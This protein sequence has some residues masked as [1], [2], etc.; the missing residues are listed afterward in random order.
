MI[1]TLD[2]K[3][4]SDAFEPG[5]TLQTL[6]SDVRGA[7]LGSR[8]VVSIMI[9]GRELA[10]DEL[11]ARLDQPVEGVAQIELISAEPHEL[12]ASAFREVSLLLAQIG[13]DHEAL[14]DQM[15]SGETSNAVAKFGELL[16][17]WQ[18]CQQAVAEGS[19]M[20][21]RDMTS[22]T[23]SDRTVREHLDALA[24]TLRELRGAFEAN[25]MILLSDMFRYEMPDTCRTWQNILTELA[26][27][28]EP[29]MESVSP[30]N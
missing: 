26:E 24:D 2:G 20:L 18:T 14:A 28:I 6:V 27:Q 7:H 1:V 30:P 21:S 15:Q 8:M 4:L 16:Q 9:D 29:S 11:S 13:A 19:S 3:S 22:M 23:A 12:V 10:G 17:V 25:D 5:E